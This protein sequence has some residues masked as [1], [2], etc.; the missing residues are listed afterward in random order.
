MVA[1]VYYIPYIEPF[2]PNT[3]QLAMSG[4]SLSTSH[5][6]VIYQDTF[7]RFLWMHNIFFGFHI[8]LY[9]HSHTLQPNHT[10]LVTL[11]YIHSLLDPVL[12]I[13]SLSWV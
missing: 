11:S 9:R 7:I 6:S 10:I 1:C 8:T 13:F 2:V 4:H 12:S 5:F 3:G